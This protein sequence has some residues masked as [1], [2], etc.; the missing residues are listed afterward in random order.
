MVGAEIHIIP[1]F[2]A[3]GPFETSPFISSLQRE[4]TKKRSEGASGWCALNHHG[5][6]LSKEK[7]PW[8]IA[9]VMEKGRTRGGWRRRGAAGSRGFCCRPDFSPL[10]CNIWPKEKRRRAPAQSRAKQEERE[11]E[12]ERKETHPKYAIHLHKSR[13]E[14]L[15]WWAGGH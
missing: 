8:R 3:P 5:P 15:P 4:E 9:A 10:P 2:P 14:K 11:R 1:D 7:S 12:R 13:S 6:W